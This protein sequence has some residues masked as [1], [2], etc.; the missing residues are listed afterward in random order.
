M[1]RNRSRYETKRNACFNELL[2]FPRS[3]P[4]DAG[5]AVEIIVNQSFTDIP[6]KRLRV[7]RACAQSNY[8][9]DVTRLGRASSTIR[10]VFR[11]QR[12]LELSNN[13]KCSWIYDSTLLRI[14][15]VAVGRL[16]S[17]VITRKLG[18]RVSEKAS[19]VDRGYG[20]HFRFFLANERVWSAYQAL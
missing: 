18:N 15:M 14:I 20:R 6:G 10:Y 11:E 9:T 2:K 1:S 8:S 3:N 4:W 17:G 13:T 19:K 5:F 7:K 12:K 16:E